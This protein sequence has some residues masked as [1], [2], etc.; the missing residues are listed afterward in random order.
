MWGR[1]KHLWSAWSE[2]QTDHG[3]FRNVMY[4]TR[5]CRSQSCQRIDR[6]VL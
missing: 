2:I 1:H 5:V 6:R 4:Q 3:P